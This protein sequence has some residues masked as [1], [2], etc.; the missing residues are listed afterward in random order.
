MKFDAEKFKALV[1]YVIWKT[2]DVRNF[3]LTKL[4]KTLWF[5]EARIFEAYGR[6]LTGE[7]FTRRQFGPVPIHLGDVLDQLVDAGVVQTTTEQVYDHQAKRYSTQ[8]P[9]EISIFDIEDLQLID[10]WIGHI[11]NDH[12][13]V[14]ISEKSHDYGWRIVP[15]GDE[16]PLKAFLAS[17]IRHPMSDDELRWVEDAAKDVEKA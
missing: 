6:R 16:L 2:T 12:T 14:S 7:T 17:R 10:W 3:G 4:N 9:P 5:A 8:S 15:E 11:A 13:A 1:V